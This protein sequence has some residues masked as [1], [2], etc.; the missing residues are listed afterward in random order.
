M[1]WTTA[2]DNARELATTAKNSTQ[3]QQHIP[4]L[5]KCILDL[6]EAIDDVAEQAGLSREHEED[7]DG[8]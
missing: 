3:Q 4:T 2:V 5:I 1:N 6:C 8:K 7:A